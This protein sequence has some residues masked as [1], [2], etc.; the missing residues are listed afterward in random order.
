MFSSKVAPAGATAASAQR[1]AS[2]IAHVWNTEKPYI[3]ELRFNFFAESDANRV[4]KTLMSIYGRDSYK[5]N[6]VTGQVVAQMEP[7]SIDLI[8][9]KCEQMGIIVR[10][11]RFDG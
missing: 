1:N 3:K 4:I 11:I 10:W 7:Y 6:P 5:E 2:I 8:R 9:K